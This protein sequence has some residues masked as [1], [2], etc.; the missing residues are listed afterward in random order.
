M[1]NEENSKKCIDL[2][3]ESFES[4]ISEIAEIL[5]TE[6]F[7]DYGL[8]FDLVEAGSFTDQFEPYYRYQISYGGPSEE[9]RL[10]HDRIEFWYLDWF[11]GACI[12][13]SNDKRVIELFDSFK[14]C[15]MIDMGL[16]TV[17]TCEQCG[18][19][20]LPETCL[21]DEC[22]EEEDNLTREYDVTITYV[23]MTREDLILS[24]ESLLQ[25]IRAEEG[26]LSEEIDDSDCDITE[27]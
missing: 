17:W 13:V 5:Y 10:F 11:D 21:C 15:C 19:V 22:Q 2:V 27:A 9:F 3:D 14:D 1:S 8:C 20:I 12:D 7:N 24:L 16:L 4:R 26:N 6:E 18:T 25:D 23:D